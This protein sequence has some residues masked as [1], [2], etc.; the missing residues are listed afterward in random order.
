[1]SLTSGGFSRRTVLG[2]AAAAGGALLLPHGA[3]AQETPRRGGTLRVVMIYNP[4]ALDP[5]TGRNAPDFNILLMLYDSLLDLDLKTLAPRPGLARAWT[6]TNP[7]T[8]VLDLRDDVTFHDGTR[9]DAEVVK[10]NLDRYRTDPRSNVKSDAAAV[11]SVEV[12]GPH[13]V[14]LHLAR[15]NASLPAILADR[16][17]LM[18][19]PASVRKA[20]K[21]NVDRTPVGTGPFKFVS[22]QDNDRVV[23]TRND[24]YWRNGLPYLD[25]VVV[26]I[27]SEQPT[28]LR[29]IVAGE[30]D[31]A[32]NLSINLK[33]LADRVPSLAVS[34]FPTT[35]LWGAYLNIAKPPLDNVKVRQAL[36]WGIDREAMNKVTAL[37]LDTPGNGMLPKAH[38]ACDPA[39]FNTYTYA[40]ERA[41]RLLAEAGYP[42][43]IDLPMLGG[44]DQTAMQRQ[45]MAISQLAKAGIRVKL[46]P[47]S[48]QE[49]SVQFFGPAKQ[50][51]ARFA[52]MGG[53]AD[54]SQQ[55]DDLFGATSYRNASGIELPG[56]RELLDASQATDDV[57]E[58][59]AAIARLQK[60]VI[61]N[62]LVLTFL[63]QTNM[64][65]GH[66]AVKGV[67]VDLSNK[68]R[69]HA[70]WIAA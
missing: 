21:G 53:F 3:A 17:G 14:A 23:L 50:G 29:S 26:R 12:T 60:F 37:G 69:F 56:Y 41:R 58:R 62:A 46:T 35:Y 61:D 5:M 45:E 36:S 1:M 20:D 49:T 15:H 44:S 32:L 52:G 13:Q 6:W 31:F 59:K 43:G 67:A 64:F 66:K 18:V 28:G 57:V 70:A 54:P 25:G 10:F 34:L 11:E 33:A 22:W 2:G 19:S 68:P 9:F 27:I 8:L 63:F 30:N 51:S 4:A 48:P 65:V 38:W 42:D 7:T 24:S 16:V 55:Y 40:P 39:T 47:G